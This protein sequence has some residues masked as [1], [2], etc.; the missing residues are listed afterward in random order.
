MSRQ[1]GSVQEDVGGSALAEAAVRALRWDW[2]YR[3]GRPD[4]QIEPPPANRGG[5]ENAAFASIDSS[6]G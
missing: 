2:E 4:P 1:R 3:R 6:L 5:S